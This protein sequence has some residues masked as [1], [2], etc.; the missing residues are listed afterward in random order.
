MKK[1]GCLAIDCTSKY[2]YV[3]L[4]SIDYTNRK[5]QSA[6]KL[7]ATMF[8]VLLMFTL[9]YIL[10]LSAQKQFVD[11]GYYLTDLSYLF[12]YIIFTAALIL[13]QIKYWKEPNPTHAQ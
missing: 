1:Y 6:I 2:I 3:M 4:H 12:T 7:F 10:R 5:I 8:I 13:G 9:G 11:I